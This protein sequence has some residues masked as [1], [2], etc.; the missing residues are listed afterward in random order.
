M[1]WSIPS[2]IC[3]IVSSILYGASYAGVSQ[4][5]KDFT[6]GVFQTFRMLFGLIFMVGV[7]IIMALCD[8][9]Y[10]QVAIAHFHSGIVPILWLCFG[11]LLNLGIPHC[12]TAIAQE[13]VASSIVQ[14]MQ[15]FVPIFGSILSIF[16]L[17]EEK[18]TCQK[19][20]AFIL[21]LVGVGV[22]AVPNFLNLGSTSAKD[23]AIGYILTLIAMFSFGAAPV[24]FK[25]KTPNVDPGIS[26]SIQLLA[27]TIFELIFGLIK[28]GPKNFAKNVRQAPAKAWMWPILIGFLVSGVAVY[29]LMYICKNVG[30]FA[31]NLVP[32]GQMIVGVIVGVAIMGDWN[33]YAAWEIVISVIGVLLLCGSLAVSLFEKKPATKPIEEE[34]EEAHEMSDEDDHSY[35]THE[36]HQVAEL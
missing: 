18:F 3:F 8:K 13:F 10:K 32:F 1:K 22:S 11:G 9:N 19:I 25:V 30:A 24:L 27:S 26:S 34:E 6:A 28:D 36:V 17:P 35:D 5:L 20:I 29:G 33:G 15:P 31:A 14:I 23:M 16:I 7:C 21:A 12:L 2:I 4:A